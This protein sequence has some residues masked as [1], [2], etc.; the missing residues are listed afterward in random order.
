MKLRCY[1]CGNIVSAEEP[2]ETIT[3][4]ALEF[5]Q[6]L[7]READYERE[8]IAALKA[9]NERLQSLTYQAEC[10]CLKFVNKVEGGRA[11][12]RETYAECKAFLEAAGTKIPR[13]TCSTPD[14]PHWYAG[15]VV[16]GCA[17]RPQGCV[18]MEVKADG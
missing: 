9:E 3:G 16:E 11:H 1:H 13:I 8:E 17:D 14:C 4:K 2:S 7:E 5:P 15:R 12:S 18:K 10:L 6:Y